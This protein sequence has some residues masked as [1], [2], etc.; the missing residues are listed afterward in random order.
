MISLSE[1]QHGL[2]HENRRQAM[3]LLS[4]AVREDGWRLEVD[5]HKVFLSARESLCCFLKKTL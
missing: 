3:L 5:G 1:G 4:S 2:W